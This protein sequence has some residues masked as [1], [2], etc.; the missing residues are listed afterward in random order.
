[1][2]DEKPTVARRADYI[3]SEATIYNHALWGLVLGDLRKLVAEAEG[4]PD[5]AEVLLGDLKAHYSHKDAW[6]AKRISVSH[7]LRK[8]T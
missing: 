6:L 2:S 3:A 8:G 5:N 4:I 1:M 7:R